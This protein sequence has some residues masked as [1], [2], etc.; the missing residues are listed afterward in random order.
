MAEEAAALEADP[1]P[2]RL[3]ALLAARRARAAR[4]GLDLAHPGWT[5]LLAL[6]LAR[7]EDRPARLADLA[8]ETGL[9]RTTLLRW[10]A[11]L[12][13]AGHARRLPFP[14]ARRR[15]ARIALTRRGEAAMDLAFAGGE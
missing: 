15:G 5:L 2:R 11:L 12:E 7:R 8:A 1:G 3:R 4:F 10:L 14:G 6:Y 13:A 9:P